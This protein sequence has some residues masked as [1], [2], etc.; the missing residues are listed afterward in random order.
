MEDLTLE[1]RR[2]DRVG[3]DE[4]ER[5]YIEARAR[6]LGAVDHVT[7]DGGQAIWDSVVV[8]LVIGAGLFGA[9]GGAP[10]SQ[11]D[12]PPLWLQNAGFVWVPFIV[13]SSLAAWFGMND[14]AEAR[15]SFAE[16]AVIFRRKHN[17]LMCWLYTGTFG[18]F[19]GLSAGFPLLARSQ[20]PAAD[21]LL[22]AWLGPLAGALARPLGG[23]LADRMG[24]ARVTKWA[25]VAM[26]LG[27]VTL[28][29]AVP[30]G[31]GA[32]QGSLPLFLAAFALLFL[33]AGIGNGSS[34]RMIA[35]IFASP[36]EAAAVLG[37]VS[38]VAAYGGFFIPKALGT[39]ISMTGAPSAA[40]ALFFAFYLS[41][42]AI[43]WWHYSR[44]FA[45]TPC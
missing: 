26:T 43:T 39:S 34:Y 3:V 12:G 32:G 1:V 35:V 29:A 36:K 16:Q 20:F 21:V 7:A 44:R 37:F 13:A 22:A 10:Q 4:A 41:C 45:P 33:T 17:W 31:I 30:N 8:P 14:I 2:I 11:A 25:F 19:I 6:E 23:W 28:L 5:R 9:L 24:G 40:L 15:G 18:S 38:A 42:I 27:V